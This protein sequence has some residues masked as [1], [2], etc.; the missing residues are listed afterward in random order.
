MLNV[1]IEA[2]RKAGILLKKGFLE[3]S[4]VEVSYK[5]SHKVV[6]EYDKKAEEIILTAI[7]KTFPDHTILSEE[8]GLN[9]KLSE[10]LWIIDPLDGTS[11]FSHH[12]P[13]FAVS[14]ALFHKGN[15]LLSVIYLPLSEELY[16]A[17]A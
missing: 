8:A 14:I 9:D 2:A 10:Y 7:K 12:L 5:D 17:Q 11:N 3:S 6:T 4:V 1:A 13:Y 16:V 15:P